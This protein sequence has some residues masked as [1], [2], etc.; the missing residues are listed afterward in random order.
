L[1]KLVA[2]R[3]VQIEGVV[4]WSDLEKARTQW[5]QYGKSATLL[6]DVNVYGPVTSHITKSVARILSDAMLFLQ[7]PNIVTRPLPYENPQYLKLPNVSHIQIEATHEVSTGHSPQDY[8]KDVSRSELEV[9]L[10]HIQQPNFLREVL[11]SIR[12]RTPLMKYVPS[13]RIDDC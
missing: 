6:M 8:N 3:G 5:K 9:I 12:I 11:T 7:V 1:K 2:F 4:Q 13:R 10:D